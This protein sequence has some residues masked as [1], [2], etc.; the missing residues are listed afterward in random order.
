MRHDDDANHTLALPD[1]QKPG[2]AR[3]SP[4]PQQPTAALAHGK[5]IESCGWSVVT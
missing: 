1:E 5:S 2:L 4:S 3:L